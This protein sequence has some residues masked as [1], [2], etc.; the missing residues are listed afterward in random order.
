[1]SATRSQTADDLAGLFAVP[2]RD[3][4][5]AVPD[6]GQHGLGAQTEQ[7]NVASRRW[8]WSAPSRKA[9]P[10]VGMARPSAAVARTCSAARTPCA[11]Y[12]RTR[13]AAAPRQVDELAP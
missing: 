5:F 2:E 3:A 8:P 10:R 6:Q 7:V 13:L 9:G 12:L 1:M 11:T 4:L